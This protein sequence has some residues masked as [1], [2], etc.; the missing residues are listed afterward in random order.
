[1]LTIKELSADL[2]LSK[3][4]ISN[5]V[6]ELGLKERLVRDGN[7]L[8][9]PDDVEKDIR[10]SFQQKRKNDPAGGH[11]ADVI[12]ILAS[13]LAEK[14]KQIEILMRQIESLQEQ[15]NSL[16]QTVQQGNYLLANTLGAIDQNQND[17]KP[18]TTEP[19]QVNK[20]QTKKGFFRR[21]F[22]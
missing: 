13:Q 17:I 7:K 19:E 15:N 14:D 18:D 9:I 20:E 5:R 12:D 8:L 6:K 16:L 22:G 1:M 4:A 21:L 2:H 3:T 10:A 11:N